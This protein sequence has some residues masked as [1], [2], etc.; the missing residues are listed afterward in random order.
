MA[1]TAPWPKWRVATEIVVSLLAAVL[2]IGVAFSEPALAQQT[3]VARHSR[4]AQPAAQT[5]WAKIDVYLTDRDY[6]AAYATLASLGLADGAREDVIAEVSDRLQRLADDPNVQRDNGRLIAEIRESIGDLWMRRVPGRNSWENPQNARFEYRRAMDWWLTEGAGPKAAPRRLGLYWKLHKAFRLGGTGE[7][8]IPTAYTRAALELERDVDRRAHLHLLL[9]RALSRAPERVADLWAELKVG[10]SLGSG[11][12]RARLLWEAYGLAVQC[13]T[14]VVAPSGRLECQSD[15]ILALDHLAALRAAARRGEPGVTRESVQAAHDGLVARKVV[16]WAGSVSPSASP[17]WF[18]LTSRNVAEAD[19]SVFRLELPKQPPTGAHVDSRWF[20]ASSSAADKVPLRTWRQTLRCT[21]FRDASTSVFMPDG[22][23]PGVYEVVVTASGVE[24]ARA[25]FLVSDVTLVAFRTAK[26]VALL[27]C[28]AAT[29]QPLPGGDVTLWRRDQEPGPWSSTRATTNAHGLLSVG[30]DSLQGLVVAR[31]GDEIAVLSSPRLDIAPEPATTSVEVM[32]EQR[33]VVRG[34]LLRFAAIAWVTEDGSRT[35][36]ATGAVPY[37]VAGPDGRS[38]GEGTVDFDD[39]G[40]GSGTV[41]VPLDAGAGPY[42]L[43]LL[44][45]D[46][47]KPRTHGVTLF[48]VVEEE[49]PQPRV[50]VDVLPKPDGTPYTAGDRLT[51]A[52]TAE[53]SHGLLSGANVQLSVTRRGFDA[54]RLQAPARAPEHESGCYSAVLDANGRAEVSV[55]TVAVPT[56]DFEYEL[57]ALVYGA[58]GAVLTGTSHYRVG[59]TPYASSLDVEPPLLKPG[60]RARVSITARDLQGAAVAIQGTLS[61]RREGGSGGSRDFSVGSLTGTQGAARLS[62]STVPVCLGLSDGRGRAVSCPVDLRPSGT[63][64]AEIMFPDEGLYS[65]AFCAPSDPWTRSTWGN[66]DMAKGTIR[67]VGERTITVPAAQDSLQIH[68]GRDNALPASIVPAVVTLPFTDSDLL[69]SLLAPGQESHSVV[70]VAGNVHRMD[71]AM[72]DNPGESLIVSAAVVKDGKV[73]RCARSIMPDR[74]EGLEI[75]LRAKLHASQ[76]RQNLRVEVNIRASAGRPAEARVVALVEDGGHLSRWQI[77]P[78]LGQP[79]GQ[80]PSWMQHLSFFTSLK[81]WPLLH[82]VPNVSPSEPSAPRL[83][84]RNSDPDPAFVGDWPAGIDNPVSRLCEAHPH[85]WNPF[86]GEWEE[87]A[88][89]PLS[90]DSAALSADG[91][92]VGDRARTI[93]WNE[94]LVTDARGRTSF[95]VRLSGTGPWTIY[96]RA[97]GEGQRSGHAALVVG[98][99]R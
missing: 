98:S 77:D 62:F 9:S 52:V 20:V 56:C 21:D 92:W 24:P 28:G 81:D 54:E 93:Y 27:F 58:A 83:G 78:G 3:S 1:A 25:I 84:D 80:V 44:T 23:A 60:E 49:L 33:R 30:A 37:R 16:V 64:S 96:V 86:S 70:H 55:Q 66:A 39:L 97:V 34:S 43:E 75:G 65:L 90:G 4:E 26:Q 68:L 85:H 61:L 40:V 89:P 72:P 50:R 41:S 7:D 17:I 10:L 46:R 42:T 35:A 8:S 18:E 95:P 53:D 99:E 15:Y 76:R 59:I 51:V 38:I 6:Q 87:C 12:W 71:L 73:Y 91:Y 14:T 74:R 57:K 32:S 31:Q 69:L 11:E 5:P 36:A 47:A 79:P 82:I 63:W 19:V 29:G 48:Q 94:A 88:P 67:V 22:L 2:F 45:A 13:G